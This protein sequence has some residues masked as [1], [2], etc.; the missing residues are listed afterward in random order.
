MA[1]LKTKA[2][3]AS[4]PK[5]IAEIEDAQKRS[6]CEQLVKIFS[7]VSKEKP[8]LWG[9]AMIGFG[10]YHYKSQRS[11]QEGDWPITAFSPRKQNI[12]L[13]IMSG[14]S[15]HQELLAKLGKH[16]A[17]TGSCIYI[18]RLADIDTK[19]LK[20]IIKKSITTIKKRYPTT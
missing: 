12:T 17:S 3:K 14:A 5:F 1:E 16:K 4:V 10:T 18:K 9:N 20:E 2:T 8:I 6:D 11:T 19:V 7:E 13:Y 15:E